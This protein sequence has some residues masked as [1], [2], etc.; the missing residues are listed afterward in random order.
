MCR[1]LLVLV[2]ISR[3]A[4]AQL[5][6]TRLMCHYY[7]YHCLGDKHEIFISCN[8]ILIFNICCLD[9]HGLSCL[10]HFKHFELILVELYCTGILIVLTVMIK[11][12]SAPILTRVEGSYVGLTHISLASFLWDIGKQNSPRCDAAECGVSSGAILFAQRNFIEK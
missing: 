2:F 12:K 9:M 5:P 8:Y 6:V 7:E 1:G 10:Q 11:L 3:Y 4:E